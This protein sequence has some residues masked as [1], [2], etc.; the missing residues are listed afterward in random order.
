MAGLEGIELRPLDGEELEAAA[1]LAAR[2]MRDNPLQI[3]A[4]GQGPEKRERVLHRGFSRLLR[5]D[6]RP[7]VG[8]WDG[9]RLVGV[10]ATA[11]PGHCQPSAGE[12]LRLAP[13]FLMAG[14]AAPRLGRW[15]S[16][17]AKYDPVEPHSHLGPVAVDPE[18]QGRGI[19]SMLLAD[20]CQQ[21]DRRG[22][23]SYLETDKPENVRLYKRFGYE[24]T[25][26]ASVLGVTSWFMTRE[27]TPVTG[28]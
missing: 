27:P 25:A 13:T 24:V 18:L 12:R 1:L 9:D 6:G 19:G 3:V 8:A 2:S 20:Y 7:T 22:M 10:A 4:I 14:R 21:L 26:D 15:M 28:E 17:W 23:L 11:E 5:L 16:A